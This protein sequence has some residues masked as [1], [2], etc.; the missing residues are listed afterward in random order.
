MFS[1]LIDDFSLSFHLNIFENIFCYFFRSCYFKRLAYSSSALK[2]VLFGS[3]EHR[4]VNVAI[5]L[6]YSSTKYWHLPR[7]KSDFGWFG[8]MS[9]IC[10]VMAITDWYSF[11]LNLQTQRLVKQ[12]ILRAWSSVIVFLNSSESASSR[13]KLLS[14]SPKLKYPFTFW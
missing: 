3:R 14:T 5:A 8:A 2:S 6:S 13:K 7:K 11:I 10:S 12:V 4:W 1:Y 9:F